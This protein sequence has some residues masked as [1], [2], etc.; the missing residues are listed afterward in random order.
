MLELSTPPERRLHGLE[1]T[2]E[3]AKRRGV[4]VKKLSGGISS[5]S[6]IMLQG[7]LLGPN[8]FLPLYLRLLARKLFTLDRPGLD[9]CL[10]NSRLMYGRLDRCR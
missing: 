9:V 6:A 3:T 2:A 7:P 1:R 10:L 5:G 8:V 4:R